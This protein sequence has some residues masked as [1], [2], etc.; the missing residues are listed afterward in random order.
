MGNSKQQTLKSK[1]A[2]TPPTART[3]LVLY[4]RDG[5]AVAHMEKGRPLVVGRAAL[6]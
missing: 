2:S 5:A 4:H 3:T 6:I 1:G